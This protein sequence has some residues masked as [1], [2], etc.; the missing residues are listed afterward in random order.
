MEAIVSPL[1]VV[2]VPLLV[3]L[4][5]KAVGEQT[6]L[7]P[8]IAGLLGV[9]ADFLVALVAHKPPTPTVGLVLGMAGVGLREAVDQLKQAAK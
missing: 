9:V 4:V 6:W 8:L 7:L 5:K 2:G 1:I 3:A